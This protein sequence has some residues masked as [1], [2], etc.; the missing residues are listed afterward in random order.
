MN[1]DFKF[2]FLISI[3]SAM[4]N[5]FLNIYSP[6][7]Q[8]EINVVHLL[9]FPLGTSFRFE[10]ILSNFV[11][12]L[13]FAFIAF[14]FF[15]SY[16]IKNKKLI[17]TVSQYVVERFYIFIF[18]LMKNTLG[19]KAHAYFPVFFLT[20]GFIFF[21]NFIGLLPFSYTTTSQ[22]VLTSFIGFSF[23]FSFIV[24]G[25]YEMGYK[26]IYLF[27]PSGVNVY[28]LPILFVIEVLSF[29][30]RPLSLAVRLFA[31]MFAGHM[32]LHILASFFFMIFKKSWLFALI[33]LIFLFLIFILEFGIAFIQA[34]VF[35]I[36]LLIYARDSLCVKF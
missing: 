21:A 12:Y 20:F 26:F 14:L 32:L 3:K 28:F 31:N 2:Y 36:L 6:L 10:F 1:V 27:L 30:V 5:N 35:T 18:D 29:I 11:V 7:E 13:F 17:P 33:P 25:I 15:L 24:V 19:S 9:S 4:L 22:L 16:G 8:F 23:F 34:Y